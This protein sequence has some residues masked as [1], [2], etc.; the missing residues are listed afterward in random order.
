[1]MPTGAADAVGATAIPLTVRAAAAAAQAAIRL[2]GLTERCNFLSPWTRWYD[3][4]D[5]LTY[6]LEQLLTP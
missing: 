3:R 5:K 6:R 4:T 1:M 2:R